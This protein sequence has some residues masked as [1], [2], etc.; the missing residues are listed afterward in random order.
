MFLWWG[1]DLIQF[2]NDSYRPSFGNEGKHPKAMGQK[3]V[4]CWEEIWYFI[5]PLITKVLS[6]GESVW[7]DDL[8]YPFTEMENLKMFTGLFSYS[9]IRDDNRQI[10]GVLVV[11]N[12][13]T[14]KVNYNRKLK[15]NRDELE[16]AINAA[17]LEPL[18]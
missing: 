13:T 7:Y 4:E 18:I 17:N 15:E 5:Y 14:E 8:Y 12:E 3:G 6:T 16:F 2:Y 1:D 11:C 10:K 9:P